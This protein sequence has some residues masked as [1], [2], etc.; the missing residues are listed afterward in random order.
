MFCS[1]FILTS[2]YHQH[3]QI[4]LYVLLLQITTASTIN[5]FVLLILYFLSMIYGLND[6]QIYLFFFLTFA[7]SLLLLIIGISIF[8]SGFWML[9]ES[10]E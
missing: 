10:D 1:V 5:L 2:R 4:H 8:K 9:D 3:A 6:K 7:L